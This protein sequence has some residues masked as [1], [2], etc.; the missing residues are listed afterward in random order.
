MRAVRD[1]LNVRSR[2]RASL[3]HAIDDKPP[4][5]CALLQI[6]LILA[7]ALEMAVLPPA[8]H[9]LCRGSLVVGAWAC[10]VFWVI[11]VT[12]IALMV[13]DQL[14]ISIKCAML[15]V[16]LLRWQVPI[17]VAAAL[18]SSY[19][20]HPVLP[21]TA[22][23]PTVMLLGA[24]LRITYSALLTKLPRA[25]HVHVPC[26]RRYKVPRVAEGDLFGGDNPLS[27]GV[28]WFLPGILAALLTLAHDAY[29]KQLP[30]SAGLNSLANRLK[31]SVRSDD[32]LRPRH[33]AHHGCPP[34]AFTQTTACVVRL[35]A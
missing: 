22:A 1:A 31:H 28:Q 20:C 34:L 19:R 2:V 25:D 10:C 21:W 8:V 30:G 15:A 12:R 4:L 27:R 14:L 35:H 5:A 13:D 7:V 6:K 33:S 18:A 26:E 24:C 23:E 32:H 11:S 16:C 3:S 9:S 29:P 17:R